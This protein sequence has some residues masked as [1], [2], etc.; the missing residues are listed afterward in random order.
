MVQESTIGDHVAVVPA[1]HHDHLL[2]AFDDSLVLPLPFLHP[3]AFGDVLNHG[4]A[5]LAQQFLRALLFGNVVSHAAHNRRGYAFGP[6]CVVIF[7]DSALARPRHHGHQAARLSSARHLA[8][9]GIELRAEFGSDNLPHWNLQ[10]FLHAVAQ[11]P[12]RGG[13]HRQQP[14]FQ[15]VDAE[16]VLA[17]FDQILIPVFVFLEG[18][19][20]GLKL[21][22]RYRRNATLL[23][24]RVQIH[25]YSLSGLGTVI[26][27]V[28]S[29]H[30]ALFS[31]KD[32]RHATWPVMRPRL[33]L[34][35]SVA[36]VCRNCTRFVAELPGKCL[37]AWPLAPHLTPF[38]ESTRLAAR[39]PARD[40]LLPIRFSKG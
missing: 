19:P 36:E 5:G 24:P 31:Q 34:R 39:T 40:I 10:Q 1:H 27:R 11:H 37:L 9:I 17:V 32:G 15:I 20:D 13:I 22:E 25:G 23:W 28:D 30:P 35:R 29:K 38:T 8:E 12:G 21:G 26:Y 14:A 4:L 33:R 2:Q 18:A 6:I 3:P 16:Q 7:P